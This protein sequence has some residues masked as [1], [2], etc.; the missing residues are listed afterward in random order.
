MNEDSGLDPI[1]EQLREL[2]PRQLSA[3][4]EERLAQRLAEAP[5]REAT[6]RSQQPLRTGLLALVTI[7]AL[8]LVA[9]WLVRE[10]PDRPTT[11]EIEI[12]EPEIQPGV[13]PREPTLFAY[14]QAQDLDELLDYHARTLLPKG[15]DAEPLAGSW[16]SP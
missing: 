12:A 7:A 1:E 16:A 4:F 15:P 8:V 9:V 10:E 2:R 5:P 14:R 11:E 6:A 13:P 3:D